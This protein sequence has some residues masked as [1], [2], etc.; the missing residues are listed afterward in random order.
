M[1]EIHGWSE[2]FEEV[3]RLAAGAERQFGIAN[4]SYTE[5]ILERLELCTSTCTRIRD[6]IED[7]ASSLQECFSSLSHLI[8][9]LKTMQNMWED[10][11]S[12]LDRQH[13]VPQSVTLHDGN[14][15]RPSFR[16]DKAQVEYLMSLSFKW[17]E[18]AAVL[19]IS[20][21]TL[22]R[23]GS[24]YTI[25]HSV[26]C[27]IYNYR[28]RLE[29]GLVHDPS[30]IIS[31]NDLKSAIQ[32]LREY[33]PFCGVSMVCGNLRARRIKVTRERERCM[34]RSVDPLGRVLRCFPGSVRRQPYSVPGPNSLWH[35]GIL[36]LCASLA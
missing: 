21:M 23:Y 19:G 1:A 31:D 24:S 25:M 11:Q 15:G 3:I 8:E 9:Q 36:L 32:E 29:Y 12:S 34:L 27:T 35:I 14:R 17:T 6:F 22:Y 7:H 30:N 5:Y 26:Y 2:F 16:V 13:Y 18:I 10:Y 28:R 4:S 20:R 33:Q